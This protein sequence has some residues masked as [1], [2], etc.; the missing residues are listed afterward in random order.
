M[1]VMCLTVLL[2]SGVQV[3]G[4]VLSKYDSTHWNLTNCVPYEINTFQIRCGTSFYF[5]LTLSFKKPL[6]GFLHFKEPT[7]QMK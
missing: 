3:Q 1:H 7:T 4:G 5:D 2:R 6:L